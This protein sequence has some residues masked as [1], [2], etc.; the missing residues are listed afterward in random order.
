ME[1]S[2]IKKNGVIALVAGGTGGHI[3]PAMTVAEELT[4]RGYQV[5][6][7]TDHRFKRYHDSC[8]DIIDTKNITIQY[9]GIKK[10]GNF[11]ANTLSILQSVYQVIKILR[12]HCVTTV[13]GFGSYIALPAIIAAFLLRI[14]R[15]IHEQNAC[16][17]LANRISSILCKKCLVSHLRTERI[18]WISLY[19]VVY[20]GM[21]IRASVRQLHY[22]NIIDAINYAAFFRIYEQINIAIIGGSQGAAVLQRLVPKAISMLNRD[23]TDKIHVFHQCASRETKA[24]RSLYKSYAISAEVSDFF[25]NVA[26]IMS[27]AHILIARS[28]SGTIAE[29]CALGTPSILIPYPSKDNHQAKNALYL[30]QQGGAIMLN[31]KDLTSE[32]IANLLK[33]LFYNDAELAKLSRNAKRLACIDAH[34]AIADLITNDLSLKSQKSEEDTKHLIR[35]TVGIG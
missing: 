32:K 23:L 5:I 31:Q 21:P 29:I 26:D 20:T 30:Y 11:I 28:G 4:R 8:K 35:H 27:R 7:I 1:R 25:H 12:A 16:M 9:I 22:Q 2:V 10:Y 17:G 15:Y 33:K 24:L 14:R 6:F 18:P 19:K 13:V 34:V 3:F